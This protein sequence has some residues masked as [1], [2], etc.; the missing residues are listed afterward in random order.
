[1]ISIK[2]EECE[3]EFLTFSSRLKSGRRFCSYICKVDA[4]RVEKIKTNCNFCRKEFLIFPRLLQEGREL[5]CS[6]TCNGKSGFKDLT[7]NRIGK[8][9]VIEL[10]HIEKNDGSRTTKPFWKCL[11]DCGNYKNICS[12][13]L[14]GKNTVSC[15]C[16]KESRKKP[17]GDARIQ[18]F[19]SNYINSAKIR[20]L[21]FE[22]PFEKFKEI[23]L[24]DCFYC[25]SKPTEYAKTR[26]CINI[27][28][29]GIDRVNSSIGYA[30]DNVVP[31]C[32]I[33]NKMK[34]ILGMNEFLNNIEKIYNFQ[35]NKN[36][37]FPP[38][39]LAVIS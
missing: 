17:Y 8:L 18:S 15:G 37:E 7:G 21:P 32:K 23:I 26:R 13:N 3:K 35:K 27:P 2:C 28:M 25:G 5:F 16:T 31:C 10:S 33:C 29:N 30:F 4:Q 11:C 36:L 9:V 19:F 24:S 14:N 39:Y 6:K 12:S 22:L 34:M 20:E 38:S 1:M